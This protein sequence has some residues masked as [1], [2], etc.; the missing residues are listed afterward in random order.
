MDVENIISFATLVSLLAFFY[1]AFT[2]MMQQG[3]NVREH[4]RLGY[5]SQAAA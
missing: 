4:S 2:R 5:S 3:G 1:F